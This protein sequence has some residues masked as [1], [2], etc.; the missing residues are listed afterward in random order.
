MVRTRGRKILGDIL[1]RKGRTFLVILSILIGVMGVTMLVSLGDLIL[2]Q[3]DAD[4]QPEEMGMLYVG[5][6]IPTGQISLEENQQYLET[7][8]A[9]PGVT[10]V[11]ARAV[12][13]VSWRKANQDSLQ[14]S[15][16][17]AFSQPFEETS[18]E[19]FKEVLEGRLPVAGQN[20]VVIERR[21]AAK[22]DVKVGDVLAIRDPR[23]TANFTEV[24]VVGIVF[25]TYPYWMENLLA[26]ERIY[27]HYTDAQAISG[28]AGFS[29][30]MVR[31]TNFDAAKSGQ[32]NFLGTLASETPYRPFFSYTDNPDS[33]L[34]RKNVSDVVG[35]LNLLAVVGMIVSAFLVINIIN[36]VVIEQKRQIGVMKSIGASRWDNFFM[37]AGMAFVYGIFGTIVGV[38]LGVL[39]A[40]WMT[41]SLAESAAMYVDGFKISTAGIFVG[42]VLGLIVPVL[43]AFI[44]VF[45]GTRVSI[46]DAMTD[47]GIAS[48][49]GAGRM[50]KWIGQ[51]PLPLSARQAVS[52]VF[53]KR[54][55]LA[56]TGLTL[57]LA[58]AA[59]MGVT[60]VF[61]GVQDQINAL[62]DTFA[63]KVAVTPRDPQSLEAMQTA[64]ANIEG[65]DGIYPGL[66]T[67]VSLEGYEGT[68]PLDAG[69]SQ[70][71]VLGIDPASPV[72]NFDFESGTGWND[73]PDKIGVVLTSPVAEQLD[74]Q[75]GDAV[76]I[77]AQGKPYEYE[78]LGVMTLSQAQIVMPWRELARITEFSD[79][80]G[81]P[82]PSVFLVMLNGDPDLEAVDN[83][84]ED[85]ETALQNAG[86]QAQFTNQEAIAESAAEGMNVFLLIF[87]M[88]S[89]IMAAVGAIGL[90]AALS[91]AVFER[92]KEIGVIR[93]IGGGSLSIVS[94]FM[95]EGLVVGVVAWLVAIP[96]S[97]GLGLGMMG[98]LPF[99][100][101]EFTY[102]PQMIVFGLVGVLIVASIASM[103]PS[104]A[105][106]RKTVS[107]ILRYQ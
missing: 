4:L 96:L 16:L 93:S 98:S 54:G 103:W 97:Y 27:T 10:A 12:S 28:F 50:A 72:L 74:V 102:P 43:V 24:T 90:L 69:S 95:V 63:Y 57:T 6:S 68:G 3:V 47:L 89:G 14:E 1:A 106:S 31:H 46:L 67:A 35:V 58:I 40:G 25:H 73:D 87:N 18:L 21:F 19:P 39:L 36:A 80:E 7:L 26:E 34:L 60:A 17:V 70:L 51:L 29:T 37:Y 32:N 38:T 20:E 76:T 45:N 8:R 2:K 91:M 101:V 99:E 105:A 44:P 33:H 78:V 81:N 77:T 86:I 56:L 22:Y 100:G 13:T 11:E 83:K 53:Q 88:T 5:V 62:F 59:F 71:N 9:I 49:W 65:I 15:A 52:N 41:P 42:A 64:L 82:V 79:A 23:N 84:I 48:N 94:Q 61:I 92:Q 107:D 55:R 30:F 75:A 85:I 66:S 104:V